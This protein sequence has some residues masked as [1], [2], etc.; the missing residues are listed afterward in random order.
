MNANE[1]NR[2]FLSTSIRPSGFVDIALLLALCGTWLGLLGRWHWSLDLLSHFRWQYLLL[3]V[4]GVAW[5]LLLKRPRFVLLACLLSLSANAYELALARGDAAFAQPSSPTLRLVSLNVHTRNAG[6]AAVLDYLRSAD[7]DVIFLMEVDAAWIHALAELERTHPDFR[8]WP[9]DDNFG[10]AIYSRVPL[11]D[12]ELLQPPASATPSMLAHLTWQGRQLALLGVHPLPPMGDH[13]SALRD[14]QLQDTAALVHKLDLPVLLV[15]DLNSTPWSNGMR[16]LRD[17]TELAYRSPD[18]A[19]TATWY[20]FH[21]LGIPIDHALA[22]PPLVIAHR[23]IGP[24]V[25]SDHRPQLLEVGW[26]S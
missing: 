7:A 16:L 13:L 21:L 18:P 3:C 25:G 17:G 20:S 2:R 5:S 23:Q 4:L 26:Q 9:R 19:W 6:K 8:T 15:G 11:R 24:D 12:V 1:P 14:A 22:T 10:L